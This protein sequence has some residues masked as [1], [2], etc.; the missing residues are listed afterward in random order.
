[1]STKQHFC[2]CAIVLY[3]TYPTVGRKGKHL[4]PILLTLKG[5]RTIFIFCPSWH[6]N[7]WNVFLCCHSKSGIWHQR[8]SAGLLEYT[9]VILGMPFYG[10]TT[11][12]N[13]LLTPDNSKKYYMADINY[14]IM[15]GAHTICISWHSA[16]CLLNCTVPVTIWQGRSYCNFLTLYMLQQ[17]YFGIKFLWALWHQMLHIWH[18]GLPRWR[19]A[20]VKMPNAI[21]EVTEKHATMR[22]TAEGVECMFLTI[23]I[24]AALLDDLVTRKINWCCTVLPNCLNT[25]L[26]KQC[27]NWGR[28]PY[29][30]E[31]ETCGITDLP[32]SCLWVLT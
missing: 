13:T 27:W 19:F 8:Q 10:D 20:L 15:E 12:C 32:T 9:S 4:L 5:W 28:V 30:P 16:W 25:T 11:K 22:Q 29:M 18:N 14:E 1:L 3:G 31:Q 23:S 17:K 24:T 6:D 2:P 21:E 26:D 7:D